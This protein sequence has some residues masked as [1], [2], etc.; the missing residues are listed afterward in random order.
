[1]V[2]LS[3]FRRMSLAGIVCMVALALLAGIFNTAM[4]AECKNRGVLDTRYCDE[5][6]DLVADTPSDSEKWLN[7]NTLVF[8]YTPVEDPSVYEN[9]FTEFHGRRPQ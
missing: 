6:G 2:Y 1:M 4:A 9:V 5:D 3:F 7:P 8:S